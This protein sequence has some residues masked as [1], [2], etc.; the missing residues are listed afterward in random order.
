MDFHKLMQW[1]QYFEDKEI[2]NHSS[3]A[4]VWDKLQRA[5]ESLYSKPHLNTSDLCDLQDIFKCLYRGMAKLHGVEFGQKLPDDANIR[6][7]YK[8]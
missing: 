6:D 5:Y 7:W 8:Y 4:L 1:H 2:V 3:D